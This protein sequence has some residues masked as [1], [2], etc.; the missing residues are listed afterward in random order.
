MTRSWACGVTRLPVVL[1]SCC[2]GGRRVP[3]FRGDAWASPRVAQ[4]ADLGACSPMAP[5]RAGLVEKW[6][7]ERE[8]R[9][10][11][12]EKE[13]EEEEEEEIN[14]YAVAEEE[15]L[16]GRAGRGAAAR[17]RLLGAT[18]AGPWE[19]RGPGRQAQSTGEGSGPKP[20]SAS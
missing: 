3:L 15:V 12:G 9:L 13:E 2:Q 16:G 8:A 17:C 4:R 18:K 14:I 5:V 6:K 7:A 11:R 1:H 20:S 10:A 19:N